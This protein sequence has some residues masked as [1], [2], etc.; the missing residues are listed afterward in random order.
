MLQKLYTSQIK[1]LGSLQWYASLNQAGKKANLMALLK[2]QTIQLFCL[3]LI[4]CSPC[5]ISF[6]HPFSSPS[7]ILFG[8]ISLDFI[9]IIILPRW[10]F[11]DDVTKICEIHQNCELPSGSSWCNLHKNCQNYQIR[12]C[13]RR[14]SHKNWLFDEILSNMPFSLV[15]AFLDILSNFCRHV[16]LLCWFPKGIKVCQGNNLSLTH[17][18]VRNVWKRLGETTTLDCTKKMIEISGL[19][20]MLTK[21]NSGQV[22]FCISTLHLLVLNLAFCS[23]LFVFLSYICNH[24]GCILADIFIFWCHPCMQHHF[25]NTL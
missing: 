24:F 19:D 20:F 10:F 3:H 23:Q 22:I 5:K 7:Q 25:F 14:F 17:S 12:W 15:P 8:Q 1:S 2:W 16:F 18:N 9:K 11:T 4:F 13:G 21:K 6:R